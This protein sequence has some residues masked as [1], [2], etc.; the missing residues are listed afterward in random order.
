MITG[1]Q[2]ELAEIVQTHICPEHPKLALTVAWLKDMGYTIR[3]GAGHYPTEVTPTPSLTELYRQGEVL[4]LALSN[5]VERGIRKKTASGA[6]QSANKLLDMMPREDL[7]T[8]TP[9]NT[10]MIEALYLYAKQYGLDAYRGHVILMYGQPYIGLDGYLFYANKEH[11]PYQLRSRPL[12]DE[13]RKTYRIG[14]TDHAWTCEVVLPLTN[15]STTGLGLVTQEEM[16]AK[17]TK[18]A[19]K[20]RSPVVAAHPWQLAQKRAEWQALRRAFPIGETSE[21]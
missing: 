8:G 20:L 2:E 21:G 1:K 10:Q 6:P 4:P 19:E 18:D 11:I 7:G 15:G 13:E 5:S 3:C 16:T 9:L 12:S 14:E 17:S